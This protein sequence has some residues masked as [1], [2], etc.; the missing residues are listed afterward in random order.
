MKFKP[1]SY[2]ELTAKKGAGWAKFNFLTAQRLAHGIGEWLIRNPEK[3][4]GTEGIQTSRMWYECLANQGIVIG[5]DSRQ[6]SFEIAQVICSVFQRYYKQIR[7]FFVS[8]ESNTPFV[9]FYTLKFKCLLGLFISGAEFLG[10]KVAVKFIGPDGGCLDQK[11]VKNI[12]KRMLDF[13]SRQLYLMDLTKTYNYW[14]RECKFKDKDNV[15]T[16]TTLGAFIAAYESVFLINKRETN[17]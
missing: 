12:E 5:F 4:V 7:T 2:G 9:H 8:T 14:V 11:H 16:N 1:S 10:E 3:R 17:A 13:A 6:S 15:W